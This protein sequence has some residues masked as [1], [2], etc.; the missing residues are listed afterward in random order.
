[1]NKLLLLTVSLLSIVFLSANYAS[2]LEG[3]AR[4]YVFQK[5]AGLISLSCQNN[6]SCRGVAY[7]II[8]DGSGNLSGYG[9]S[10]SAGWV[11]FNPRYGGVRMNSKG[12]LSG[13]AWSENNGWIS[14]AS[15][16][17]IVNK[18][19]GRFEGNNLGGPVSAASFL[20]WLENYCGIDFNNKTI[21]SLSSFFACI[22]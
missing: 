9:W 2:A 15:S 13:W 5:D 16:D 4:G 1:M 17:A 8:N 7:E 3:V 11:N 18:L 20:T 14:F 10:D 22:R 12:G 6:N 21:K 19:L